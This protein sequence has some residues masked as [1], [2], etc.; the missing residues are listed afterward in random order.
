MT[1][2]SGLI[3]TACFLGSAAYAGT[4]TLVTSA[5]LGANDTVTWGQLGPDSTALGSSF[6]A[7]SANSKSIGG[8][9]S[10]ST[11]SVVDVGASWGPA[12]GAF[13][14]GDA[15]IWAN[16]GTNGTG[17]IAL[18]FPSVFGAGAA[19]QADQPG[20]FTAQIQLYAGATSLG[21]ESLTSDSTGDAIFIGA[22]D[23]ANE[24][25]KAVFSL[26]AV[27]AGD[28]YGNA[29]GDFAVD[30]LNLKESGASTPEPGSVLML[31]G[32]LA[33]LSLLRRRF[34]RA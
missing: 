17:P 34:G 16:D 20:Q 6:S 24:V 30:T 10:A 15:V 5:G 11:G 13:V 2:T 18:T 29:L 25:T 22:L 4:L 21:T 3:I 12:S 8:S 27:T 9:F 14:N 28:S 32:G 1:K 7:T 23:T 26:T 19:I 31:V 33:G